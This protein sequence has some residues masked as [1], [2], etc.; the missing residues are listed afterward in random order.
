MEW[1]LPGPHNMQTSNYC[2]GIVR[3][4]FRGIAAAERA[5]IE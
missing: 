5:T 2:P 4:F 3:G 1:G